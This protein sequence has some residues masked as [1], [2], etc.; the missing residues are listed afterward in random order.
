MQALA[1][2]PET[3]YRTKSR[4]LDFSTTIVRR[5]PLMMSPPSQVPRISHLFRLLRPSSSYCRPFTLS[6]LRRAPLELSPLPSIP[7]SPPPLC[8]CA[9]MPNG[10]AIDRDKPL[11]GTMP[12]YAQH[13]VIR[14]GKRDWSKRIEDEDDAEVGDVGKAGGMRSG[15]GTGII[16]R[17]LKELVGRG[18]RF[19]DVSVFYERM[20]GC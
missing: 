5:R 8:P 15:R 13:V 10:L 17:R 16:A 9:S 7:T 19:H 18:G 1:F 20:D 2:P 3:Q 11:H 14:T 12:Q 4:F 6:T